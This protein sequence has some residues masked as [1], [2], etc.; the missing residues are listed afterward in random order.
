LPKGIHDDRYRALIERLVAG[1][2]A[3]GVSQTVLANKLGKPQQFVS[4]Y[5]IGDRRLDAVE[6]VDVARAIGL[7]PLTELRACIS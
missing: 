3:A 4:R 7:D 1:R 6:F 2:I 5:E